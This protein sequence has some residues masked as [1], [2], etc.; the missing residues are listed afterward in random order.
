MPIVVQA[1]GQVDNIRYAAMFATRSRE[2]R[3]YGGEEIIGRDHV[4]SI[5][6]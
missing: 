4:G 6:R 3:D 2:L 1:Q 5:C